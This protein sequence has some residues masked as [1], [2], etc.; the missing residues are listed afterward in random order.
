VQVVDFR[1]KIVNHAAGRA[2]LNQL[3]P[4]GLKGQDSLPYYE[5]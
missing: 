5:E 2:G 1:D 4:A 3:I